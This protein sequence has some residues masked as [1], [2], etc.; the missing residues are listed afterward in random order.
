MC[1]MVQL[2]WCALSRV[3]RRTLALHC[4]GCIA[5]IDCSHG[6]YGHNRCYKLTT[7]LVCRWNAAPIPGAAA[8]APGAAAATPGLQQGSPT[9]GVGGPAPAAQAVV[10]CRICGAKHGLWSFLG[11]AAPSSSRVSPTAA[12]LA[13]RRASGGGA[14]TPGVR[15][16][17]SSA[18]ASA[19]PTLQV[20]CCALASGAVLL[21]HPMRMPIK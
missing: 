16:Q 12:A 19:P 6:M 14:M 20:G 17:Y 13:A 3:P 4:Y 18:A 1:N 8:C 2:L 9:G 15:Q 11:E 21:G 10:F 5:T 7:S